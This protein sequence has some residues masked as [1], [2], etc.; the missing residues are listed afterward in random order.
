VWESEEAWQR[1]R[2]AAL[3]PAVA[4]LGGPSRPEPTFRAL[5]AAHVVVGAGTA[6]NRGDVQT[7]APRRDCDHRRGAEEARRRTDETRSQEER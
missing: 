3:L 2:A 5:S 4:A 6:T 7:K 1:F